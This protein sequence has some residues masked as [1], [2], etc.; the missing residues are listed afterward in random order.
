M[1]GIELVIPSEVHESAVAD[2]LLE[3]REAG[4]EQIHGGALIETMNYA[5]WLEW[6]RRTLQWECDLIG[7]ENPKVTQA[8]RTDRWVPSSTFFA[9]RKSDGRL[10]GII[11]FR[12]EL[13]D[14]LKSFAGQ[15][16]YGVRPSE[17]GKGY[18]SEMLRLALQE[19][20]RLGISRP[21]MISCYGDNEQSRRII[22]KHGGK[23][24]REFVYQENGKKV[25]TYWIC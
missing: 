1:V 20:S 16:G 19:G 4:E 15:I 8:E 12:R 3:H 11:D 21:V 2:F 14:I 7:D 10:V 13:N 5:D 6:G 24:E 9:I 23:L 18:G 22:L 17:R 25:Q